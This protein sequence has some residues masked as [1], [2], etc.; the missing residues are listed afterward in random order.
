M[1]IEP[2]II[3]VILVFL[4]KRSLKKLKN[5]NIKG[6]YI[7]FISAGVQVLISLSIK[8]NMLDNFVI[9]NFKYLIILSYLFL[10]ITIIMNI[11]KRYMKLFL[12]GILLNLVV[13]SANEGKMPVSIDGVKG[14][15][16]ETTLP[17]REFDIKHIGIDSNT[18]FKYLSDIILIPKPYPLPKVISIG[19]IFLMLGIFIFF[20]EETFNMENEDPK[21]QRN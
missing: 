17:Y 12:I 10:I 13:I 18:K 14:I 3:S 15:N 8:Y 6:W 9:K 20:Q 1:F 21:F 4:R 16:E 5:V 2:A 7:L 19:D 11:E